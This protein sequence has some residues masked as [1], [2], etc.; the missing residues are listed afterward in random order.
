ML[1]KL[2][3][4]TAGGMT[5]WSLHSGHFERSPGPKGHHGVMELLESSATRAFPLVLGR[6]LKFL[7]KI[8]FSPY[9]SCSLV[10]FNLNRLSQ[11]R[12]PL[13]GIV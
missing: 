1:G 9:L 11:Q 8:F 5:D 2:L 6:V 4:N 7:G 13:N 10:C 3:P 12:G